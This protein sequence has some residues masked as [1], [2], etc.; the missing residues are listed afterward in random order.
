ML[1]FVLAVP[2]LV[3]QALSPHRAILRPT[4]PAIALVV[5]GVLLQVIA[6]IFDPVA[7]LL[8]PS[9]FALGAIA[10]ALVA[11][12]SSQRFLSTWLAGLGGLA[13][14]IPIAVYGAMPVLVSSRKT[15]ST[16]VLSEPDLLSAKHIE[17]DIALGWSEPAAVLADWIPLPFLNAVVSIGDVLLIGA[18]LTLGLNARR[19]G[20]EERLTMPTRVVEGE[21][22]DIESGDSQPAPYALNNATDGS[23]STIPA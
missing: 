21:S 1:V 4:A 20:K 8:V 2:F 15:I 6:A 12:T 18:F 5:A 9:A 19:V 3:A 23:S 22:H 7:R 16:E 10:V 17:L 13:N 11:W 14:F